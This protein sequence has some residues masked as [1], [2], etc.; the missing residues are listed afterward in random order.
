MFRR[1]KVSDSE[2]SKALPVLAPGKVNVYTGRTKFRYV[3][4]YDATTHADMLGR[5]QRD[6]Y[7]VWSVDPAFTN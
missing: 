5:L 6:G 7:I 3:G 1:R 2:V 4:T